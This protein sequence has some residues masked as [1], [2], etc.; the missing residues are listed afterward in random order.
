MGWGAGWQQGTRDRQG[1]R[2]TIQ[3]PQGC[4]QWGWRKQFQHLC[5]LGIRAQQHR[6]C[7][8]QLS[9]RKMCLQGRRL[10]PGPHSGMLDLPS[11][12]CM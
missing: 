7:T 2:Y 6:V 9:P 4:T 8:P 10:A 1:R 5:L 12:L 11:T 3:T